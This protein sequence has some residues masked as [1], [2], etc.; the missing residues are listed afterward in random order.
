[1]L[2]RSRALLLLAA[3]FFSAFAPTGSAARAEDIVT[4][5]TAKDLPAGPGG[6][7]CDMAVASNGDIILR[8]GGN[9]YDPL[10]KEWLLDWNR[11]DR[12]TLM[13][14][15]GRADIM[16]VSQ[17][18]DFSL[19]PDSLILAVEGD[20]MG[21]VS[22][23]EIELRLNLPNFGMRLATGPGNRIYFY[24]GDGANA[25]QYQNLLDEFAETE[26][27]LGSQSIEAV[28]LRNK[29]ELLPRSYLAYQFS[30]GQGLKLA[31]EALDTI[32]DMEI[33]E[34][35][36]VF[37]AGAGVY[38]HVASS[39]V[40]PILV[41][42]GGPKINSI[43]FDFMTEDLY[44]LRNRDLYVMSEDV[45][46]MISSEVADQITFSGGRLYLCDSQRGSIGRMIP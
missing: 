43:A 13:V 27:R 32:S 22:R 44:F 1:M 21:F 19:T 26:A 15:P 2:L 14:S 16:L 7:S 38:R 23:G 3:L 8:L 45:V 39:G 33:V 20:K 31:F 42:A 46:R 6:P 41:F 36:A 37:A 28:R 10:R 17:L 4:L 40:Q 25:I 18:S 9:L 35:G 30:R 12:P 24:G 34:D 29:I 5:F 11:P